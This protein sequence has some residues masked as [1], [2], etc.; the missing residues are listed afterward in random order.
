MRPFRVIRTCFLL[1]GMALF[2][3]VVFIPAL[4][5]AEGRVILNNGVFKYEIAQDGKNLHFIDCASGR[6][7]L[8]LAKGSYALL[9]SRGENRFQFP[10]F[11]SRATGFAWSS[12]MRECPRDRLHKDKDRWVYRVDKVEWEVER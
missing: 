7:Y 4:S 8:D 12:A 9:F 10:R 2:C 6:D 5:Q 3:A 11:A 1:R